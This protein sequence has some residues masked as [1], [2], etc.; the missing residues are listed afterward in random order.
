[1]AFTPLVSVAMPTFNPNP[2]YL[3]AAI[4]SVLTQTFEDLELVIVEDPGER[5]ASEI[6]GA[7]GDPRIR[8]YRNASRTSG[9][10]QINQA[11]L[12]ARGR[13][14]ARLDHDDIAE[15]YRLE[16]QLSFIERHPEVQ[17]LGS[18]ITLV[19]SDGKRIG[20][21]KY[22]TKHDRIVNA[23]RRYNPIAAPSVMFDRQVVLDA[24]AHQPDPQIEII[25]DYGLWCRLA[26]RRVRF[27]NHD[28]RLL[29]YRIHPEASKVYQLRAQLRATITLKRRYWAGQMGLRDRTRILAER[30]LLCLPP[31]LVLWLFL[32]TQIRRCRR[33][34]D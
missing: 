32:K 20:H 6:I 8:Y 9:M 23:L 10:E 1:M 33:A 5:S 3:R 34:M 25:G 16:K 15:P 22:P 24:G 11:F 2:R 19:D 18:Q 27:A 21:R 31:R 7:L 14:V 17:V 4:D 26:Q 29:R 12:R 28:E 30:L 13:F